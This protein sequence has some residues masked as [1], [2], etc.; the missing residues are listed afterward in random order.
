[1]I[2]SGSLVTD[3]RGTA[4][5]TDTGMNTELGKIA[6]MM[7][8]TKEKKTPLQMSLDRF[9]GRLAAAAA[10]MAL[11]ALVF[12]LGLYRGGLGLW[13]PLCLPWPWRWQ[14]YRRL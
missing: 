1:M 6:L 13:R 9:S 7:N 14:P 11:S 12:I 2:F 4:V 8:D 3:G 5:V 10:I